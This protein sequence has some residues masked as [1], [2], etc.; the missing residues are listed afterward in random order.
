M[1][2]PPGIGADWAVSGSQSPATKN[3]L[4]IGWTAAWYRKP[5][6]IGF[7]G[8]CFWLL[9]LSLLWLNPSGADNRTLVL[10]LFA[11]RPKEI[12]ELKYQPLADYLSREL[13]DTK[14]ELRVL[15]Q[16]QLEQALRDN[17]LDLL[18]TN[19][20]HYVVVRTQ[21]NLTGALAT[22][23]SLESGQ[24]TSQLG[25]VII[26]RIDT[27]DVQSLADLRGRQIAVPGLKFLGV[28]ALPPVAS[29]P[30]NL[31]NSVDVRV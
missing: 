30:P 19:P 2:E 5:Q 6:E 10:G 24:A 13:G 21:F 31:G 27:V 23:V 14:V 29:N 25:G 22:L 7:I 20:S 28:Q 26:T 1:N 16:E 17:Q 18:F 11:Y 15:N 3:R 8:R 12:L 9:V 4:D